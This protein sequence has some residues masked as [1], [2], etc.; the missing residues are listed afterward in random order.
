ME[1]KLD[2]EKLLTAIIPELRVN[3]AVAD[4]MDR[5]LKKQGYKLVHTPEGCKFEQI[6]PKPIF[7]EGDN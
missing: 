5:E 4:S 6:A 3:K 1:K 7:K 2:L